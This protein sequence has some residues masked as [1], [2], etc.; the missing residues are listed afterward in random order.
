MTQGITNIQM[1]D[2]SIYGFFNSC[3]H[4]AITHKPWVWKLVGAAHDF[5]HGASMLAWTYQHVLGHHPYTNIDGADP[6]IVT[7][8]NVSAY[9]LPVISSGRVLSVSSLESNFLYCPKCLIKNIIILLLLIKDVP[10][11]R[12]IKWE[13]QWLP[14]YFNQHVYVPMLYCFVSQ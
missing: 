7:A 13:Q 6:D 1:N 14:R 9:S 10:D 12:R 11:I 4:F 2:W 3:S 5:Y 8:G